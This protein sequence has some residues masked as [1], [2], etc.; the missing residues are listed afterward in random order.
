M[1]KIIN[2]KE[3]V[4]N[5]KALLKER[6]EKLKAKNIN[7]KLAVIIAN[8]L[9]STKLYIKNKKKLAKEL[10]IELEEIIYDINVTNEEI[11]KKIEELNNDKT[12][13]GILVQLP[14]YDTL[15]EDEIIYKIAKE[16]DVDCFNPYN[17][18]KIMLGKTNLYPCTPKGIIKILEATGE[19]IEGK[20]AVVIGRSNIVGKP[21]AQMLLSKNATVTVCHSKTVDLK[22]ETL[23]ADILIVAAGV[24]HF[25]NKEMIKQGAIVIDVGINRVNGK[26]I[27]D[28]DTEDCIE[29]VKFITK[30]PGGVGL[31]TVLS[32]ME[33]LCDLIEENQ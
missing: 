27:G 29:K 11:N 9:D 32:V 13:H 3:I 20:H 18:G 25:I 10:G 33:N 5:S 14:L 28:V 22:E 12:V 6:V 23:R 1:D 16:K 4:E 15:K 24:P 7:P 19:K 2:V 21:I 31:T 30:V 17:L 8:D 26:V